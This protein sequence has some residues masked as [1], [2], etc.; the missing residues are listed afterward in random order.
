M[1]DICPLLWSGTDIENPSKPQVHH[2]MV[3]DWITQHFLY[4]A[5]KLYYEKSVDS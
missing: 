5:D 3:V 1:A 4:T 2:Y